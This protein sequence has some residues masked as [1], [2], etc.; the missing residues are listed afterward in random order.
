[1]KPCMGEES[2]QHASKNYYTFILKNALGFL[3]ETQ[4]HA[5]A[6]FKM[7][8][9]YQRIVRLMVYYLR[10]SVVQGGRWGWLGTGLARAY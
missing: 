8:G 5:K 9:K 6:F 10:S 1:M 2:A 7:N 4:E 3:E